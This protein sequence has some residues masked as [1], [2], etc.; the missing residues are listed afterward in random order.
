M[1]CRDDDGKLVGDGDRIVFSYGTPPVQVNALVVGCPCG[2]K[3][4]LVVTG[5][6]RPHCVRLR[7]LRQYVGA[8]WKEEDA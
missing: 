1:K 6:H 5:E 2:C 7:N 3:Q 4:L 8:W